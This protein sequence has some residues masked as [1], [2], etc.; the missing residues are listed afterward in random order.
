[1][2]SYCRTLASLTVCAAFGLGGTACGGGSADP[3]PSGSAGDSGAGTGG[4]AG[5]T[6]GSA[7]TMG[8]AGTTG[9][10]GRGGTTGSAGA[11]GTGG[12]PIAPGGLFVSLAG[13]TQAD[14]NTKLTTAVNRFFGIGTG[15]S[16]TPTA[17]TGY[18]CYYE[19]PQDASMAFIW[20]ADSDD[21]RSEGMSYGMMIAVQMNMQTQFDRLWKF[22]KTYM[23]FPATSGMSAWRH[24]FKWQGT[25]NRSSATS[26]TATFSDTT[27]PAPDGDEYF[28]A[29]LYLANKRWG[30][31]G[32]TNY[33]LEADNIAAAMLHNAST[34]DG[35][36]P[37]IHASQ[38][39]P[40]FYPHGTSGTF[41]DPSYHLPA[42][43]ELFA[44]NGPA[45]DAARWRTV[46][47]T[48]R[49][50]FV[51]SAHATTGLHPDYATF[52]GAPTTAMAGDGHNDF[53]YDAWRVVMNMALDYVWGSVDSREKTQIEKYHTFFNAYLQNGN[54]T[55][56]LFTVAGAT[57]P[58][59]A[60]PR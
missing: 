46:A 27:G 31:A 53:G 3:G 34:S 17:A 38:N 52:A 55:Q 50:F 23:Q 5:A 12:V 7:G 35:R 54:V 18:R 1:M 16:A 25:V 4:S 11:T 6:M 40:V 48:S 39:M 29:A 41:T 33:K 28:A 10:A 45:G 60:R 56:S 15:E 43:Y 2:T 58:A 26:W 44:A 36:G 32:A 51:T 9:S 14:V 42:F 24:Y 59:A 21:V 47:S 49:S 20:A 13:K 57:P 37:I 30:S 22:A 19:L 8:T